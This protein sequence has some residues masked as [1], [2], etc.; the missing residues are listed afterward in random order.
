M[1]GDQWSDF[2]RLLAPEEQQMFMADLWKHRL[3]G[4]LAATEGRLQVGRSH[5]R[6]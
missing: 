4:A 6:V 3:A 2:I 5:T 1:V